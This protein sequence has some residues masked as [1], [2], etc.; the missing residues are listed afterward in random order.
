MT[1]AYWCSE[2]GGPAELASASL[3]PRHPLGVCMDPL[4][5]CG[6]APQ[7]RARGAARLPAHARSVARL[8]PLLSDPDERA[9]VHHAQ[10]ARLSRQRHTAHLRD[11]G[12]LSA[13]CPH[14]AELARGLRIGRA[15]P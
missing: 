5:P 8:V 14:C 1:A 13:R 7:S 12:K 3:D 4:R 11:K 9:A 10:Q 15:T 2:C 6:R